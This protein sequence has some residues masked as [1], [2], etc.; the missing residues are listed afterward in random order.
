MSS[1]FSLVHDFGGPIH[2]KLLVLPHPLPLRRAVMLQTY[3]SGTTFR[4]KTLSPSK[5]VDRENAATVFCELTFWYPAWSKSGSVLTWIHQKMVIEQG[6]VTRN[7]NTKK[8]QSWPVQFSSLNLWPYGPPFFGQTMFSFHHYTLPKRWLKSQRSSDWWRWR[9]D[10]QRSRCSATWSPATH[11]RGDCGTPR[12]EDRQDW[13]RGRNFND[14][15][16]SVVVTICVIFVI[17]HS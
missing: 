15:G 6:W 11:W 16:Y 7:F 2:Y 9:W 13:M 12:P 17:Q 10:S 5:A 3:L 14:G 8:D 1:F 4:N